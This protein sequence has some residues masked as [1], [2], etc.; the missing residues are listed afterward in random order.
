VRVST[1]V[2][3]THKFTTSSMDALSPEMRAEVDRA[4]AEGKSK[5]VFTKT[6]S[7]NKKPVGMNR[8]A[9]CGFEFPSEISTCPQCGKTVKSSF[10]ARLF[11]K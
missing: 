1:S 11:G 7:A 9:G 8:C 2:H 5:V 6:F 4:L 10:W 3:T